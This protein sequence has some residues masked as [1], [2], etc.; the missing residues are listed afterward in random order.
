MLLL[1]LCDI[2]SA[3][4]VRFCLFAFSSKRR[5]L[6]QEFEDFADIEHLGILKHCPTRWLSLLRV[7]E[8]LL[9]Q[10]PAL[11]AY[12]AS[13]EDG[14]KP[15]RVKRVVD[16]F[17]DPYTKLTLLFLQYILP[18]LMEFNKLF[19]VSVIFNYKWFSVNATSVSCKLTIIL[20]ANC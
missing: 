15:G 11:S 7:V 1:Y 6:F 20:L 13:H 19:Q 17:K 14:E 8:R 18:V 5:E 4:V 3:G 10:Y 16:R 9:H 12:F 2:V